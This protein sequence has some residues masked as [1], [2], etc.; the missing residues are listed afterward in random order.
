MPLIDVLMLKT[1][2]VDAEMDGARAD[3]IV[4]AL[5]HAEIAIG[6]PQSTGGL[7]G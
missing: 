2:L 3:A 1:E 6:S 5:A 4:K 7:T